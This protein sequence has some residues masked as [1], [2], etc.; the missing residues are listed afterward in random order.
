MMEAAEYRQ[1]DVMNYNNHLAHNIKGICIDIIKNDTKSDWNQIGIPGGGD[2]D[3]NKY[4]PA[5]SSIACNPR[6]MPFL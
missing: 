5:V 6:S 2:S 3:S 4:R 1:L